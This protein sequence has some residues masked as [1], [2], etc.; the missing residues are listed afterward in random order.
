MVNLVILVFLIPA[1]RA[2]LVVGKA[3]SVQLA[4]KEYHNGAALLSGSLTCVVNVR[5]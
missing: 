1:Y 3:V 2:D 4:A 5:K